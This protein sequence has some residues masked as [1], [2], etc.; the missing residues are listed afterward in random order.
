M[1]ALRRIVLLRHGNTVGDSHTRFHGS[2]DVAL[3]EEGKQQIRAAGHALATEVFEVVAASPLRRSW[4]S[5][6]LLAGGSNVLLVPEFREIHFGRWEG[7]TAREIQDR[8]PVLYE[9][10]QQKAPDFEFPSGEPRARFRER[11][12]AG[13]EKV[14]NTGARNALL[15]VHK[16]V[17]RA[18]AEHLLGQEIPEGPELG[19]AVSVTRE[20]DA[21]IFGRRSSNPPALEDAAA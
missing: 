20:G 13:L 15:V 3:S 7:L 10:W 18:I 1:T 21:W 8:D 9:A 14:A 4:E 6:A 5:A 17:I 2:S 16:G 11:V 12:V 19:H